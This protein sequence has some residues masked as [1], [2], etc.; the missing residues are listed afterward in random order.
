MKNPK[1]LLIGAV[2]LSNPGCITAAKNLTRT[3]IGMSKAQVIDILN[4]PESVSLSFVSPD[5]KLIE[6]WDYK[7]S[8]YT[9]ATTLS[10]YFDIYSLVFVDGRLQS[11]S[12]TE[13][14]ARLGEQG[15]L[16][17]LG[18]PDVVVNVKAR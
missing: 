16:K 4:D 17:L 6:V 13:K 9:A 18:Y 5:K 10:P 3:Q 1:W 2:L 7:L 15:A 14:G 8:Q 11:W 12:K